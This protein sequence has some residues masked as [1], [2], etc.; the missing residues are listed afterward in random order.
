MVAQ[1]NADFGGT[2][3]HLVSQMRTLAKIGCLVAVI[4]V[5]LFATSWTV[6]AANMVVMTLDASFDTGSL[7]G[8][9]FS[10]CYSFDADAVAPVGE[11][12]LPLNSFDFTLRGASFT[13][14]HIFQGGQVIF[15]DSVLENVTASFQVFLPPHS[16]VKNVTFGFGGPGIIGYSDLHDQFGSGSFTFGGETCAG[17][18]LATGSQPVAPMWPMPGNGKWY[19]S[20]RAC[21]RRARSTSARRVVRD[22]GGSASKIGDHSGWSIWSG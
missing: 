13:R 1:A 18:E 11:T 15:T 22:K 6:D 19:E 12:Y 7:A 8:T 20:T 5:L 10:V 4:S 2:M 14:N 21:S 3:R 16:P 9:T 17:V